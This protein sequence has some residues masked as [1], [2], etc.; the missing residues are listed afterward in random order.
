MIDQVIAKTTH[1]AGTMGE[2]DGK[3]KFSLIDSDEHVTSFEVKFTRKENLEK[4]LDELPV[5][6]GRLVP[7]HVAHVQILS[8]LFN[9]FEDA[10]REEWLRKT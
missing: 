3:L 7:S 5:I 4:T 1:H 8:K 10:L 9:K 6:L 2:R